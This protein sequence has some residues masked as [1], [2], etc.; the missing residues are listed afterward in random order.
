MKK[1]LKQKGFTLIE[2]LLVIAIIGILAAVLFVSLGSQR[3]RARV[4]S[5][6]ESMRSIVPGAQICADQGGTVLGTLGA[7]L[8]N[9]DNSM[10]LPTIPACD[11]TT[12]T[13]FA[14]NTATGDNWQ[15]TGVCA[16]TGA[17]GNCTAV[18]NASGCTFT[19]AQACN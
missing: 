10:I 15:V 9:P 3:E 14:V 7:A 1:I 4:T 19:P 11:G 2:L 16:R 6:K 8:C 17:A 18:C 5:F 13:T 12:L